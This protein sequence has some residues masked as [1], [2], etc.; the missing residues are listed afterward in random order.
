METTTG[1][2]GKGRYYVIDENTAYPSVTTILGEM[3]D[4]SGL[5][6]WKKRVGEKQANEISKNSADRGTFMHELNERYQYLLVNE[7]DN[8]NILQRTFEDVL[9]KPELS[10]IDPLNK[11]RGKNLFI[12]MLNY[13]LF[14]R[15]DELVLQ[16]E[17]LWSERGGGY[18]GRVDKVAKIQ[19]NLLIVDY[20]SSRKPKKE[21]WIENY[22]MQGAAYAVAYY[23]RYNE[24]PHGA[25]I[26]IANDV[27]DKPQVFQMNR[28]D[29]K[30]YFEK[31]I[32][33]VEQYHAK[34]T[35]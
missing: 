15:I 34:Y 16:E 26:W 35:K 21:E 8:G 24:L 18:A 14:D 19:D 32:E 6:K 31:F 13:G 20:K 4:K 17:A 5:E 1:P 22:K 33:L 25:E 10:E 27:N 3:T 11:E 29:I 12:K 30:E 28:K 2:N 7:K 9:A 23:D